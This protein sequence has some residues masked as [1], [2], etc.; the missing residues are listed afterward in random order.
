MAE[1]VSVDNL[2]HELMKLNNINGETFE[3]KCK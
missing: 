3:K 2:K 1:L